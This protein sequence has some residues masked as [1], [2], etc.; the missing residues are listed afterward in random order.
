MAESRIQ[1]YFRER[2]LYR[3]YLDYQENYHIWTHSQT[4][5]HHISVKISD[6]QNFQ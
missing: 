3:K 4:H 5:F 6:L 1:S 2:L